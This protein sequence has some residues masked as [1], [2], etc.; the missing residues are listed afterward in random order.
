MKAFILKALE[1][2][3]CKLQNSEKDIL[4]KAKNLTEVTDNVLKLIVAAVDRLVY[5]LHDIIE[6]LESISESA[7]AFTPDKLNDCKDSLDSLY[8]KI[9][10][11]KTKRKYGR[12]E[13]NDL[14]TKVQDTL[15]VTM[16]ELS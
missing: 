15:A 11:F 9:D 6:K 1:F 12:G 8:N 10:D 13:V 16:A 2:V 4:I 3:F 14:L 7:R 5:R